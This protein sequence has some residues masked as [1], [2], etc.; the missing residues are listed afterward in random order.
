MYFKAIIQGFLLDSSYMTLVK[1]LQYM[2][3]L[4]KRV[5]V[6][7]EEKNYKHI[8]WRQKTNQQWK[9]IQQITQ[10]CVLGMEPKLQRT[11]LPLLCRGVILM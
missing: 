1:N 5:Y 8:L 9:Q 11:I 3:H 4:M 7:P 10:R 6:K 2:L